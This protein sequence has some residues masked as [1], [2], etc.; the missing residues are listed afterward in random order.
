MWNPSTLAQLAQHGSK[1]TDPGLYRDPT[2]P[3]HG[4][5]IDPRWPNIVPT[6]TPNGT[7]CSEHRLQMAQHG[8]NIGP[9][10]IPT[11][12]TFRWD[13]FLTPLKP[14]ITQ[15]RP[16][17]VQHGPSR[18]KDRPTQAQHRPHIGPTWP[19]HDLKAGPRSRHL[20]PD[21]RN[22]YVWVEMEVR[23]GNMSPTYYP[24]S[25]NIGPT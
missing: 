17:I 23:M 13:W 1:T 19:R 7:T 14:Q 5:N 9:K 16:N 11:E 4:P 20:N 25:S 22:P 8:P 10:P 2:W 6:W 15:R 18:A 3:Q 21:I 12:R 24:F